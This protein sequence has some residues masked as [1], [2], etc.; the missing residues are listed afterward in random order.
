[1]IDIKPGRKSSEFL[2]I[3]LV[4]IAGLVTSQY[5][6]TVWGEIA[7]IVVA[8]AAALGY[9]A[10]RASVKKLQ[11]AGQVAA[12]ERADIIADN[13]AQRKEVARAA[14]ATAPKGPTGVVR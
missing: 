8:G 1:M 9:S 3:A 7:G 10:H 6:G 13:V 14:A 12:G 2:I 11:V 4:T 5:A